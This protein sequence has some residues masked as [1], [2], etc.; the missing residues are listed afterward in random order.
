MTQPTIRPA[1]AQDAAA[2][3]ELK[4]ATF[5][6]TFGPEGFGIPYPEAD[7]KVFEAETYSE[8]KVASELADPTHQTWVVDGEG[9][10]IAYLHIGPCKLPHPKVGLEDGELYQI[11]LRREAQGAG[12]GKAL[13]DLALAELGKRG[14]A[15]WIGVWSGNLR[16]QRLYA[17]GG[18]APVGGYQFAVG[19]WHD[20]EII[21]AR[22]HDGAPL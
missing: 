15:I 13:F 7:L 12:L 2:L 17:S 16:A 10:L 19:D 8:A 20:D 21:M 18:F 4:L 14:E 9:G 22:R 1:R 11:Y 6:Q 5:R 3:A